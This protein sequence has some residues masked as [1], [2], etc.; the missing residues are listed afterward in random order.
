[1]DHVFVVLGPG[2]EQQHRNARILAQSRGDDSAPAARSDDDVV[3]TFLG[4]DS[5]FTAGANCTALRNLHPRTARTPRVGDYAI[6]FSARPRRLCSSSQ[7]I[8]R[9][10]GVQP[11]SNRRRILRRVWHLAVFLPEWALTLEPQ[12]QFADVKTADAHVVLIASQ[13]H[14]RQNRR[15]PGDRGQFAAVPKPYRAP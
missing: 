15:H 12:G 4:H 9:P 6:P 14:P 7:K 1:M 2:F 3:E 5:P 8:L 11:A 13:T 10:A